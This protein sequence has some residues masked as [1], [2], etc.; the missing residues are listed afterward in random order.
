MSPVPNKEVQEE[1]GFLTTIQLYNSLTDGQLSPYKFDPTFMLIIDT[2]AYEDYER[3]H[4]VT[5]HHVGVLADE[6][7]IEPLETYTMLILYDHKGLSHT[8]RDSILSHTQ[9][10]LRRQGFNPFLLRGGFDAFQKKHPYLCTWQVVTS[11]Y[12]RQK[13]IGNYPSIVLED[14]LYL[15]RADQAT[16]LQI[17]RD[18][19]LT[20]IINVT[21]ENPHAFSHDH[22][23]YLKINAVDDV[24][25]D[26]LS[27]FPR[28]IEF[29]AKALGEGGRLLVHCN[30]GVSRSSTI[31]ISY[32][33][34]TRRW[35]LRD[36]YVFLRERRPI[37]RPNRNFIKQL[38]HFEE[39]LFGSKFTDIY[40][41]YSRDSNDE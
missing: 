38:L 18:L 22:I 15:G 41:W 28:A 5:A 11:G 9:K 2:R 7:V 29:I 34:F 32:L 10:R 6:E 26:L 21:Q 33:M 12:E 13:L 31:L 8:L 40:Q 23:K 24:H 4:I 19:N 27:E 39:M 17:V 1:E 16:N 30:L 20:H 3:L 36:A 14:Q 25:A 37:V 35:L